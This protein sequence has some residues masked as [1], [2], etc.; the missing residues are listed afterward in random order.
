MA[1]GLSVRLKPPTY[2]VEQMASTEGFIAAT[3]I[4]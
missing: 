1:R 4:L 3:V 2:R